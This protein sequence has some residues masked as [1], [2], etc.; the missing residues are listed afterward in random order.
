MAM[1]LRVLA[2]QQSVGSFLG[3][4]AGANTT[5]NPKLGQL[6]RAQPEGTAMQ[7]AITVNTPVAP[8]TVATY[9]ANHINHQFAA[10]QLKD[11]STGK[12]I[13]P[14]P[15]QTTTIATT[16]GSVIYLRWVKE[17]VFA[18]ILIGII[19]SL[20]SYVIYKYLV[21][22]RWS[23]SGAMAKNGST[24]GNGGPPRIL[25]IPWY[26][27]VV[28]AIVIGVPVT[29]WYVADVDRNRESLIENEKKIRQLRGGDR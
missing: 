10:K 25:G 19:I 1:T 21:S 28:P 23:L 16:E 13:T 27:V 15:T 8:D 3:A 20:L 2:T 14:W 12:L 11:P 26:Y 9:W 4:W 17:G 7:L 18:D 24:T 29:Y 6:E 22:S 5:I